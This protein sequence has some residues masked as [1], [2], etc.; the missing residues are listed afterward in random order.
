MTC[1]FK[2]D[3]PKGRPYGRREEGRVERRRERAE[4][5]GE[6]ERGR[7]RER[8]GEGRG[9]NM[10]GCRRRDKNDDK[11]RKTSLLADWDGRAFVH[12]YLRLLGALALIKCTT[13]CGAGDFSRV[14]NARETSHPQPPVVRPQ[15]AVGV[16]ACTHWG[17]DSSMVMSHRAPNSVSAAVLSC[18]V[19]VASCVT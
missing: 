1:K 4:E 8:R 13:P 16:L 3:W 19:V 14:L 18:G 9:G 7:R 6:R 10:C 2:Q 15:S 17:D 12:V 11:Q 5:A